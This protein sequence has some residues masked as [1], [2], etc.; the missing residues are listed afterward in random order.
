MLLAVAHQQLADASQQ[1]RPA[2]VLV[3]DG[4]TGVHRERHTG[5]MLDLVEPTASQE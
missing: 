5:R 2:T 3:V 4:T 1:P